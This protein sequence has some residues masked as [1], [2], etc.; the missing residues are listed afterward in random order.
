MCGIVGLFAKRPNIKNK[1]GEH[2]SDMLEVMSDRE[3][4][5]TEST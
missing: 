3:S 5:A 1:L 2:I 4:V